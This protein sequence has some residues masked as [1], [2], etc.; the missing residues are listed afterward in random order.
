MLNRTGINDHMSG[1]ELFIR[2][3]MRAF[4]KLLSSYVFSYFPFV[5]EGRIQDMGSEKKKK[6]KIHENKKQG[7]PQHATPR[8]KSLQYLVYK[9]KKNCR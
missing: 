4:R 6:K 8:S 5:F 7:K 2:F 3:T 1:K 9:Y